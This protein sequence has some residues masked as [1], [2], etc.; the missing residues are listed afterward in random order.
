MNSQARHTETYD[1]FIANR[2]DNSILPAH[3]Y[4]D[5]LRECVMPVAPNGLNQVHLQEGTVTQA[6]ESAITVAMFKYARDN[7]IADAAKL[8]VLGF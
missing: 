8:C 3:D 1:R 7:K 5:L 6:N 4:T 2:P